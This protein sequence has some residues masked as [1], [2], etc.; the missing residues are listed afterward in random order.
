MNIVMDVDGKCVNKKSHLQNASAILFNLQVTCSSR[1]EQ[2]IT[3]ILVYTK[4]KK[5]QS[6]FKIKSLN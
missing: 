4:L 6:I 1:T 2:H 5:S 3:L